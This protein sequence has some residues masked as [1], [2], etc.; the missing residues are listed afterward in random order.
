M[1]KYSQRSLAR[2]KECDDRLVTLFMNVIKKYDCSILVGHRSEA[3]QNEAYDQRRSKVQWPD[4]KH[5]KKPSLAVDAVRYE[6]GIDWDDT[7]G[8]YHFA[9]Y[10]KGIADAMGI[11]IRCG[12]DW[13]GDNQLKDQS[14]NDLIHFEL[15]DK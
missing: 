1:P 13:D 9:G 3:D 11:S 10:V 2:L 5:N 14:F 8:H 15:V 12:C 4:S 6:R 7:K